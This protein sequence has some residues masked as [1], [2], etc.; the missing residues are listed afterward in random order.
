MESTSW[1]DIEESNEKIFNKPTDSM[2]YSSIVSNT[3][4]KGENVK[5][6]NPIAS[7]G[8]KEF[9]TEVSSILPSA[10]ICPKVP[11]NNLKKKGRRQCYT[12]KPRGKVLKHII[13][14]TGCEDVVFHF[15]L[16]KRPI[17][18]ITPKKHYETLYEIPDQE[19]ISIFNSIQSFC[20]FWKIFTRC[21][22][23]SKKS[24]RSKCNLS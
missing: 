15:D 7:E 2:T 22:C 14:G 5:D 4:S 19:I 23:F 1:A 12:C 21:C 3:V 6:F 18:L 13:S 20:D 8:S 17:I 16:H 10:P 24:N 9:S 11:K